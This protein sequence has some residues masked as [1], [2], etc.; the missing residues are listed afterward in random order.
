MVFGSH[1]VRTSNDLIVRLLGT[2]SYDPLLMFSVN[3]VEPAKKLGKV[4][5][6]RVRRFFVYSVQGSWCSNFFKLHP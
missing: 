3:F 2:V 5:S 1:M 4:D 6:F